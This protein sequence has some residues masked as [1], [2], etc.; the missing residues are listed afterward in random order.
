MNLFLYS[1]T[2]TH[3]VNDGMP[4]KYIILEKENIPSK[5]DTEVLILS[6]DSGKQFSNTTLYGKGGKCG[7]FIDLGLD[8]QRVVKNE[9]NYVIVNSGH[10]YKCGL[11]NTFIEYNAVFLQ[12]D[13]HITNLVGHKPIFPHF[14]Q[15]VCS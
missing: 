2:T 9:F 14:T 4:R 13:K 15:L 8:I 11:I 12:S 6:K 1:G 3:S 7:D 10:E 5:K